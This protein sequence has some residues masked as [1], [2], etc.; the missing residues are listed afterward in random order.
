MYKYGRIYLQQIL[1]YESVATTEIYTDIDEYQLQSA[2]N[3][4]PLSMMF[5]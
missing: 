3:S 1:G 5:D 2:V 4:N